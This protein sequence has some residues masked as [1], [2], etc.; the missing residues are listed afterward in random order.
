MAAD[1]NVN[2][3]F[4]ADHQ[5][6]LTAL[7]A[8]TT[9][10]QRFGETGSFGVKKIKEQ[11]DSASVG[12]ANLKGQIDS[13]TSATTGAQF[14]WNALAQAIERTTQRQQE[15]QAARLTGGQLQSRYAEL[16]RPGTPGG[17]AP[18]QARQSFFSIAKTTGA[19]LEDV[20]NGFV[21]AG[22]N[23]GADVT[24]EQVRDVVAEAFKQSP[25]DRGRAGQLASGS[26][27]MMHAFR[28]VDS[29]SP[30]RLR[31]R[32]LRLARF[33]FGRAAATVESSPAVVDEVSP[34]DQDS[35][36]C[37]LGQRRGLGISCAAGAG[38]QVN[39]RGTAIRARRPPGIAIRSSW[40]PVIHPR[41][42]HRQSAGGDPA[43]I[44]G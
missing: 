21:E 23:R 19:S 34:V 37:R 30:R 7:E 1:E 14:A 33:A 13:M 10:L 24:D 40:R 16:L 42:N 32:A 44:R 2:I 6:A 4:T 12:F 11:S 17:M 29:P 36:P 41:A 22:R 15:A 31:R 5:Q 35:I 39:H 8:V 26:L 28:G 18:E 25:L 20:A 27:A 3:Q 38:H 43:R 9:A